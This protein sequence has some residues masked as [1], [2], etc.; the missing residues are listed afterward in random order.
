[1]YERIAI[2]IGVV[3][4]CTA[5]AAFGTCRTFIS[6]LTWM[7]VRNPVH[8]RLYQAFNKFHL[9]YWWFFGIFVL[10][11]LMMAVIHTGLPKAGDP[12]A[13]VH[14]IILG[15]GLASMFSGITLF[16]S[17]RV[18]PRLFSPKIPSLSLSNK[19]YRSFFKYHAY[20]WIIFMLLVA[21]H[22]AVVYVHAGIWPQTS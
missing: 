9:Y 4:L 15:L 12:D 13:G 18:S 19:A 3:T 17:C 5:L 10:A 14:W 1:M 6:L 22:F 8:S 2:I 11:H 21:A 16:F 7:G 20:Y